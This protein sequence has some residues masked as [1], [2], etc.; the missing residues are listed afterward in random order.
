[1]KE[2][3]YKE[4]EELEKSRLIL[5]QEKDKFN[6]E[7]EDML[8][9]QQQMKGRIKL[10]V[11][12]QKFETTQTTLIKYPSMFQ[13]M[14]SGRYNNPQ[15]DGYYFIDRD[16]THFRH[17]LNFMIDGTLQDDLT[18]QTLKLLLKEAN[19]YNFTAL[20]SA[21]NLIISKN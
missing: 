2:K 6:N 4:N 18:V 7:K 11:G 15:E 17:I 9:Y 16:G 5:Q 1:M 19:Y 12:S 20:I 14:F 3:I 21:I 13:S 10:N 8:K